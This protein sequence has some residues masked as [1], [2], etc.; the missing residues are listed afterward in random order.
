M[1]TDCDRPV[2]TLPVA[3]AVGLVLPETETDVESDSDREP[4]RDGATDIDTVSV[5]DAE[6][7]R[8]TAL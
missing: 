6:G 3:R 7:D 5:T 1:L 4:A 8:W 2:D